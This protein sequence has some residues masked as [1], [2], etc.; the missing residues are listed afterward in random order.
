MIVA[1]DAGARF[2]ELSQFVGLGFRHIVDVSAVDHILFLLALAAVY[3]P[4][5]WRQALGVISA[6]TVGHSLTLALAVTDA[7]PV[8]VRVVEFLIP[9]TILATAIENVAAGDPSVDGRRRRLRPLLAG[10]FGLVHGAGFAGYLKE[11]F[12]DGIGVPLFGFN[13]GIELGQLVV[14][15]AIA[16]LLVGCDRL[17]ALAPRDWGVRSPLRWR[18]TAV[19]AVAGVFAAVW[20]VERRPW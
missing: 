2:S 13:V 19:S 14:L 5:D 4:R 6:F 20:A 7:M 9:I 17:L 16:A 18:V 11:L 10:L 12:M 8:S 15:G 3:R 1:P